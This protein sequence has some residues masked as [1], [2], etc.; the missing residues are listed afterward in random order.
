MKQLICDLCKKKIDVSEKVL[1]HMERTR[2]TG[3]YYSF[4]QHAN[5]SDG[6]EFNPKI[7]TH[8]LVISIN[9]N[10]VK[11]G[12]N[13]KRNFDICDTCIQDIISKHFNT[14]RNPHH[15]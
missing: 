13:Y 2:S 4:H 14:E 6:N 10:S 5:T 15:V 1:E 8:E 7:I 12:G 3:T 11:E 9:V